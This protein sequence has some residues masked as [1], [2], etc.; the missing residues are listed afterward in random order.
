MLS[1]HGITRVHAKRTT[2]NPDTSNW[3]WLI[4]STDHE[5]DLE[6]TLYFDTP[7][8]ARAF[9]NSLEIFT[10]FPKVPD[11]AESLAGEP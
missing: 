8:L 4:F 5:P 9:Y 3:V 11:E 1:I 6:L 10:P 7:A 2:L